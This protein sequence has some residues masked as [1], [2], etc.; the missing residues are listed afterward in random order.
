M[1]SLL[2]P[3]LTP[4][5]EVAIANFEAGQD[6]DSIPFWIQNTGPDQVDL[7][8]VVQ[9][10]D[11]ASGLVVS[12]GVP[13]LDEL[14]PRARVT[15]QGGTAPA[16]QLEV[17]DWTPLGAGR[18]LHIA[19]LLSGGIRTGELRFRPPATAA[20]VG[21]RF[22][23]GVIAAEHSIPVSA[24]ARC[25]ILAGLG[26]RGFSALLAPGFAVTPS[27]PA[28][29]LVTVG[30]GQVVHRGRLAGLVPD[31]LE[32]DQADGDAEALA[33]GQAYQAVLSAG[34]AGIT[35]TKGLR[36]SSPA[37][38]APPALETPIAAVTVRYQAGGTTEVEGTDI[39]DL[40]VFDRYFA[41]PGAGLQLRVHAGRAIAG[42]TLR[43][44]SA[45]TALALPASATRELWQRASGA[46]ELV[47]PGDPP[48][49]T[50][51]L[52]PLWIVTTD[53]TDV[54]DLEDRR[55]LDAAPV[56][57]SLR[58]DLPGS[59]GEIG[60]ALVAGDGL[61][62][63]EVLYRISDN[64]AGSA[65]QTQIEL[66]VEGATLY[67]SFAIADHRPAWA[68]DSAGLL[69]VTRAHEV[70]ELRQGQLIKLSSV[71]HPIGGTPAWA[72]A[73]LVCRRQ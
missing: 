54:T 37:R 63:E 39:V 47:E 34:A 70:T 45:P 46:W 30:P 6:S 22:V 29:E 58:G 18:G 65:G 43:Y 51:A 32:L 1:I 52:G 36:A 40:R 26:D 28:D 56:L 16:Q 59:P 61:V 53:A 2:N 35:V 11:P 15:G 21:W 72:E 12:S 67:P 7:V 66:L 33:A 68:F 9:A 17:T 3:D 73:I 38:P 27:T 44:H 41:E 24:G 48:P 8:L 14:W 64:G 19:S 50:T 23:L 4:L 25:G 13:P 42:G 10:E 60:S 69:L 20:S 71:E 49:E 5:L 55:A 57:I 31:A 62:L